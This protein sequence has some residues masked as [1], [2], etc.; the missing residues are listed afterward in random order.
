MPIYSDSPAAL[1]TDE[2]ALAPFMGYCD[3]TAERLMRMGVINGKGDLND[4]P[5]AVLAAAFASHFNDCCE[6]YDPASFDNLYIAFCAI[7]AL[8]DKGETTGAYLYVL[9][10]CGMIEC[11]IPKEL[12]WIA[13]REDT[14]SVYMQ[15]F[16][17]EVSDCNVLSLWDNGDNEN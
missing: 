8:W 9:L 15:K 1:I 14:L 3:Q 6:E 2:D 7:A 17:D 13:R 4:A 5:I 16:M 10:C 12:T 11:P